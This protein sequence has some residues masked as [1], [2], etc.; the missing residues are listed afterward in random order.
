MVGYEK[1]IKNQTFQSKGKTRLPRGYR[2]VVAEGRIP[3]DSDG[4]AGE[5][6]LPTG[7]RT[8]E[9]KNNPQR[10]DESLKSW[11]TA[12][13][14][15]NNSDTNPGPPGWGFSTGLVTQSCENSYIPIPRN[16]RNR[17]DSTFYE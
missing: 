14:G 8:G 5:R 17:T 2:L 11:K 10:E 9:A 3:S 12:H 6:L 16:K 1:I 4:Y 7:Q 13:L 15:E